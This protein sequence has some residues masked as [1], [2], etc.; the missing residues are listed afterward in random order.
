MY[1]G[2]GFQILQLIVEERT[3]KHTTELMQ[4]RV[5]DRFGMKNT[6]M[7][8]R[9]DFA[10][11]T[12]NH[13]DV[14]G[15]ALGHNQRRRPRAAG[16][17][18]TTLDDY[19]AFFAGVLRREGL[20]ASSMDAM[21]GSQIEVVSPAQFPSHWPGD[22]AIWRGVRLGYGLGWASTSRRKDRRSSRKARTTARTTLRSASVARSVACCSY[23]P[24]ATR[25]VSF[26]LPWRR[27]TATPACRG[28]GWDLRPTIAQS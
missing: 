12:T 1:P 19:A 20:S 9:D 8:W 24:A 22:T 11:R 25:A 26:C 6:S 5:F 17:M 23:R 27:C 4:T 15:T 18:D 21:L 28:S 3:G 10:G 14:A 16:S 2:E 7:A 13:Y